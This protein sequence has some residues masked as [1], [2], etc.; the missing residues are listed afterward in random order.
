MPP[1]P[2]TMPPVF[3][4]GCDST[5]TSSS[6]TSLADVD[7]W[8][9]VYQASRFRFMYAWVKGDAFENMTSATSGFG[10]V[11]QSAFTNARGGAQMPSAWPSAHWVGMAVTST[12]A[13]VS[14]AGAE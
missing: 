10:Y 12:W 8:P 3:G 5:R 9:D 1:L 4:L 11:P 13:L 6:K 14:A 7:C 2:I